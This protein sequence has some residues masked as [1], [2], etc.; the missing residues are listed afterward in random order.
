MKEGKRKMTLIYLVRHA[1]CI[2]NVEKRLTGYHDY[3]LTEEGK[4]QA[5]NLAE[6]LRDVKFDCIFSS[7][8][9][10]T[11]NTV[12]PIAEMQGLEIETYRDLSEM[13]FGSYDGYT[14]E[15]VDKLDKTILHNSQKEIMGIPKQEKTEHVQE[16]MMSVIKNLAEENLNKTILICS[17]GISIEAF[18][19]GISK[20]PFN[21]DSKKYSQINTSINIICYNNEN[22]QFEIKELNKTE[23]LLAIKTM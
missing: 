3:E 17:H 11:V 10:R 21:V 7:P 18:L 14:W 15:E 9:K 4:I 8:F 20:L 13:N 16:R 5:Q 2:G 12:R 19:R 23:H 22:G 1:Q 6:Y